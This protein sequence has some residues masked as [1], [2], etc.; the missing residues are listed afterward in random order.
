METCDDKAFFKFENALEDCA[1]E[2]NE[3]TCPFEAEQQYNKN[4]S[5][6]CFV[7]FYKP[8]INAKKEECKRIDNEDNIDA[9]EAAEICKRELKELVKFAK[10]ECAP[11]P[12]PTL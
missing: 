1:E 11:L 4:R 10:E 6:C 12:E 2:E 9:D 7:D 8:K 3:T 5:K